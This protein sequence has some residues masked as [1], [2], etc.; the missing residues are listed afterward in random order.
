MIANFLFTLI[1]SKIK[2]QWAFSNLATTIRQILMNYI[3]IYKFLEQPEKEWN[4]LI[5]NKSP[6]P[7]QMIIDFG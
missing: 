2:R 3:N 7:D 1:Q 4:N 6:D 5:N